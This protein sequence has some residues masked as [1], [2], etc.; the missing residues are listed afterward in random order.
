MQIDLAFSPRWTREDLGRVRVYTAPDYTVAP[1]VVFEVFPI[2]SRT[3]I[4]AREVLLHDVPADLEV[5]TDPAESTATANG[6][7]ITLQVVTLHDPG[8]AFRELRLLAHY[9]ALVVQAFVLV[10]AI[11]VERFQAHRAQILELITTAKIDLRDDR[12]AAI[13]E[14]WTM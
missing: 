9:Q 5:R 10:R 11:N 8:G 13:S 12:P 14:L 1:D 2:F 3:E 4:S 6:W 7:P